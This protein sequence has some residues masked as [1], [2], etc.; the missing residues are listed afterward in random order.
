MHFTRRLRQLIGTLLIGVLAVGPCMVAAHSH[1]CPAMSMA[2]AAGPDAGDPGV[3]NLCLEH[4]RS[5][6]QSADTA[7]APVVLPPVTAM[8]Y[9]LPLTPVALPH[10]PSPVAASGAVGAGPPPSHAI[11]H[12]V[13][14]I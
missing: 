2:A 5:G 8:L 12:C 3:S 9:A 1:A 11:L 6:Q 14:R 4:C 7:P 10:S 13:F